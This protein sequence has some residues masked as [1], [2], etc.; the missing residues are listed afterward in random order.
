MVKVATLT[1]ADYDRLVDY[2][3]NELGYGDREWVETLFTKKYDK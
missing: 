3:V 1:N 2:W